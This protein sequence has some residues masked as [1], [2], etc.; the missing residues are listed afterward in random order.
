MRDDQAFGERVATYRRLRGLTQQGLA[1]RMHRSASWVTKI[2]RGERRVDSVSVLSDLSRALA[3]TVETLTAAA[4][5]PARTTDQERAAS[6]RRVLDGSS[7][8]RFRGIAVTAMSVPELADRAQSLREAYTYGRDPAGMTARLALL[9]PDSEAAAHRSD[10]EPGASAVLANA[11]R[12]ASLVLR[13]LGDLSMARVAV[14]RAMAAA[15]RSDDQRLIA[16]IAATMSVQL[17]MQGSCG[18]GAELAL[19]AAR[20]LQGATDQSQPQDHAIRGALYLSAAQ[21]AARAQ[22]V[23]E[24]KELLDAAQ[25]ATAA[26]GRDVEYYCLIAGPTNLAIQRVGILVDLGRPDDAVR[27]GSTLRPQ[28]LGSS[29]RTG[30]HYLHLAQAYSMLG[31]DDASLEALTMAH[32]G[33]PDLTRHD[34]LARELM[35]AML[36]RRRS[37]NERLRR[38]A[39]AMRVPDRSS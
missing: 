5:P 30:Y 4:E 24:S 36:R 26:L 32:R 21:A 12:L 34:P 13:Q 15:E 1:Q 33:S 9:L 35:E 6:L 7:S 28:Q 18:A 23:R 29:N 3:V 38:L 27:L 2:E 17:M 25:A 16:S 22:H 39:V 14:D 10:G 31:R 20:Y 19:D 11:L 8:L 37:A